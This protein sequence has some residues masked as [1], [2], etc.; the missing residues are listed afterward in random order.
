MR[1]STFHAIVFGLIAASLLLMS[2]ANAADQ[3]TRDLQQQP[4]QRDPVE[5]RNT[6]RAMADLW[7]LSLREWHRYEK[8][9]KGLAQYRS[10]HIDPIMMLGI[11]ARSAAERRKYATQLA[12]MAHE[13]IERVLAFQ[14]AYSAAFERLYPNEPRIAID[15]VAHA[16]T[17]GRTAARRLG[18]NARRRAVFVRLHDC[19]AC[20]TTV[21]R[22]ASARTPMDIF[23]IGADSDDAIRQWATTIGLDPER[24]R[25]GVIT[26]NHAPQAVADALADTNLPRVVAR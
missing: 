2:A 19:D 22:L 7:G 18:L 17:R 21:K 24:V 12:R 25:R 3:A 20:R 23:V 13:R 14:R 11:H 6:D 16:L 8:L 5:I 26:L 15:S 4:T 9:R 10:E 1:A